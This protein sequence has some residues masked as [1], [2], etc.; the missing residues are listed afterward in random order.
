MADIQRVVAAIEVLFW[1]AYLDIISGAADGVVMKD[2]AEAIG[3][4]DDLLVLEM[5]R[6]NEATFQPLAELQRRA[7]IEGGQ[8]ELRDIPDFSLSGPRIPPSFDI[9]TPRAG[10]WLRRHAAELVGDLSDDMKRGVQAALAEARRQGRSP[11]AT[12]LD[13]AGRMNRTTGKREG[14]LIGLS[15]RQMAAVD[16]AREG[17]LTRDKAIMRELAQRDA[18]HATDRRKIKEALKGDRKLTR[19]DIDLMIGRY[20]GRS[21]M[22][23]AKAIANTEA[24]E[25][26]HAG[27]FEAVQQS[28]D[29]GRLQPNQVRKTWQAVFRNTRDSH[30]RLH[31]QTKN[32]DEP[33]V[34]PKTEA[35]LMHPGDRSRKPPASEVVN[36]QCYLNIRYIRR[37]NR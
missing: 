4:G 21:L 32:F 26:G 7:Y 9:N 22:A 20:N 6:I 5:L 30:K 29:A 35:E 12:A 8:A 33:F 24:R 15:S 34:S 16:R 17:L 25:A 27:A 23:R 10:A 37:P 3:I 13:L 28:I 14:G 36:C 11:S 2:L 19:R 31:G 1:Q 18:F